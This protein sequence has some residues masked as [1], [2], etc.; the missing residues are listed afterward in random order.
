MIYGANASGKLGFEKLRFLKICTE[1]F[2]KK[3]KSLIL[4][5]SFDENTP[6]QNT[7]FELEFVKMKFDTFMKLN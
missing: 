7:K 2:D 6:N 5:L 1:P 3:Q 4:N